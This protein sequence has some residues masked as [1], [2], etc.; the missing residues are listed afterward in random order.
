[1]GWG[2]QLLG[3]LDIFITAKECTATTEKTQRL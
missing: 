1:M 3:A 2:L